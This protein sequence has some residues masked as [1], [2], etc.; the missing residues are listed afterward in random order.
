MLRFTLEKMQLACIFQK[1]ADSGALSY[2]VSCKRK[3]VSYLVLAH[4]FVNVP[5]PGYSEITFSVFNWVFL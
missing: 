4:L 2:N 3:L 5:R 1:L